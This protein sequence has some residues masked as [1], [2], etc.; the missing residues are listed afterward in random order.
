ME[1]YVIYQ[2]MDWGVLLTIS[3][4]K[5]LNALNPEVLRQL[6]DGLDR[7]E[8]EKAKVVVITGEGEK[9]FVAGADIASM[10]VMSPE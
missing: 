4:P 3:R 9:S 7:C 10:S 5:A 6:K 1:E 8:Q 2:N